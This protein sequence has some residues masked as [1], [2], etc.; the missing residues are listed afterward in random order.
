T[1][2]NFAVFPPVT[3]LE[4]PPYRSWTGP[5]SPSMA[6]SFDGK[7]L[8]QPPLE[9]PKPKRSPDPA[10][11]NNIPNAPMHIQTQL[12]VNSPPRLYLDPAPN[13]ARSHPSSPAVPPPTR[14]VTI[15]THDLT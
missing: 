6:R 7:S 4:R 14:F 12:A 15:P 9:N 2:P 5:L 8:T 13:D 1:A 10:Q 3:A 11:P